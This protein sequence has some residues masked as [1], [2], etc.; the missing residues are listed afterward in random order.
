LTEIDRAMKP[1]PVKLSL[2]IPVFNER[3]IISLL[4]ERINQALAKIPG[5]CEIV[6]VDDGSRDE[7]VALLKS[8]YDGAH[9]ENLQARI[10]SLSRNFGHQPAI[11]AGLQA[12]SGQCVVVMDGDLQDPPELIPE[13]F[14]RWT[15]GHLVVL[16]QRTKRNE[17]LWK[18]IQLQ[19]FY[20]L[21]GLI[22]DFPMTL[23]VGVFGLLDR[24]VVDEILRI[25]ERNRFLPGL[26]SWVGF[27]A[28]LIPY[29]RQDR[30]AGSPKQ[31]LRR[32]YRYAFDSIFAFSYKPLRFSWMF[33]GV[34]SLLSFLYAVL[35]V[36]L[37]VLQINVVPGFTTP[38]VA[39]LFLGGV[40][41]VTI[42]VL[43]E[44][45]GRIYDEVKGRPQYIVR[46]VWSSSDP[47][48]SA[49]PDADP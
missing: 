26:R 35:L 44:Y 4:T 29:E 3:E 41:L 13:M 38:T 15:E 34:V 46:G 22:S 33:G 32:L 45:L 20:K 12:A 14:Q 42:G 25:P 19:A 30:A 37:R 47:P 28:F 5:P 16:P 31:T 11:M 18:R 39:I 1:A 27:D 49:R 36:V 43:G 23:N 7:T 2:V 9:P 10:L 21:L 24:R 6:F 48:G 40:Q 17:P 8:A